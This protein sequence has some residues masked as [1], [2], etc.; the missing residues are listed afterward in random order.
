MM[1]STRLSFLICLKCSKCLFSELSLVEKFVPGTPD[2]E[3]DKIVQESKDVQ[4]PGGCGSVRVRCSGHMMGQH[5][6]EK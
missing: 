1:C 6:T 5:P 3:Q 2:E 4:P